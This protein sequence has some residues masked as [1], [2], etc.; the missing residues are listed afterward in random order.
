MKNAYGTLYSIVAGLLLMFM[1]ILA[2]G[3]A[4]R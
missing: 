4:L 1:A 3:S 2:G